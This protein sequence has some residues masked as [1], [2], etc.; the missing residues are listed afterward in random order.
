MMAVRCSAEDSESDVKS[1]D[2]VV[3]ASA[4]SARAGV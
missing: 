2:F 4:P 3:F 1:E